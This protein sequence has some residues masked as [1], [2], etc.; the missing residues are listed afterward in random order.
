MRTRPVILCKKDTV[1]R[2]AERF[3]VTE[4]TVRNALQFRSES[5]QAENIREACK[6]E[7]GG[8]ET[9]KPV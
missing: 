9:V 2:L 7:Y 3:G 1:R 4:R 8:L 6:K 5:E